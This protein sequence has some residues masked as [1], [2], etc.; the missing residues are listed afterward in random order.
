MPGPEQSA[1]ADERA[2]GW[3]RVIRRI[4]APSD[5][6]S[7]APAS[8]DE[9]VE[10]GSIPS[11][12]GGIV[13][14]I[15][16]A[17][18]VRLALGAQLWWEPWAAVAAGVIVFFVTAGVLVANVSSWAARRVVSRTEHL[19]RDARARGW[20]WVGDSGSAPSTVLEAT[21]WESR[22]PLLAPS[23]SRLVTGVQR[24][25]VFAAYAIDGVETDPDKGASTAT[26]RLR[27]ENVVELALP[28]PLPELKLRDRTTSWAFDFGIR[29]PIVP[30]PAGPAAERWEVQTAHPDFA[31]ELLD[32]RVQA[33][34]AGLPRTPMSIVIRDGR[35]LAYR[36]PV[37]DAA[38]IALRVR[39]LRDLVDA[40]P[41]VCFT[42]PVSPEVA[43]A[44]I[45]PHPRARVT[46]TVLFRRR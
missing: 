10:V 22:M 3:W 5:L 1:V 43:G 40:I 11:V 29:L 21:F 44:E 41:P 37:G 8:Y 24:E 16:V 23:V 14:G 27:T 42:R 45:R 20:T 32:A 9:I 25:A 18:V 36:D 34:L 31:A 39:V 35:I 26:H 46:G 2:S 6:P 15:V 33:L 7:D 17:I 4:V 12:L 13:L 30:M 19:E 28:A 38:S